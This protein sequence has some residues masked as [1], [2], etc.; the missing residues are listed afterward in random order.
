LTRTAPH[1]S[2]RK[3]GQHPLRPVRGPDGRRGSPFCTPRAHERQGYFLDGGPAKLACSCSGREQWRKDQ[4]K[5]TGSPE[6]ARRSWGQAISA[7]GSGP[8]TQGSSATGHGGEEFLAQTQSSYGNTRRTDPNK[9][10]SVDTNVTTA[11]VFSKW[12][13]GTGPSVAQ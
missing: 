10:I 5:S 2:R 4:G 3:L 7:K 11:K 1:L 8:S 12:G 9:P 6:S 13:T